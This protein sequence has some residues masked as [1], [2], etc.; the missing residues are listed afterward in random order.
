MQTLYNELRLRSQFERLRKLGGEDFIDAAEE[1][2]E[3][4]ESILER[5]SKEIQFPSLAVWDILENFI[6]QL[7]KFQ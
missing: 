6:L 2:W 1:S 4:Y 7:I 3:N 5:A